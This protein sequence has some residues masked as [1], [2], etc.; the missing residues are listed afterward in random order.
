MKPMSEFRSCAH[1]NK[2]CSQLPTPAFYDGDFF[3]LSDVRN[4]LSRVDPASGKPK[5]TIR[6]PG[7][8]KYEASPTVGDGKIY[9]INFD[10]EVSVI[11]AAD[12][13][14]LHTVALEP[15]SQIDDVV[16]SS[17]IPLD[18]KLLIRTNTRLWCIGKD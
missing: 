11:D 3:V 14:L 15:D 4:T 2:R 7:R 10:S 13:R 6:T 9:I 12:G 17:V 18:G 8:A 16:R 5:W 1:N